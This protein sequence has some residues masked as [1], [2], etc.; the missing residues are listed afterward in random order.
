MFIWVNSRSTFSRQRFVFTAQ[1][2][3]TC[4]YNIYCKLNYKLFYWHLFIQ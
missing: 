1:F 4:R 2:F 3:T